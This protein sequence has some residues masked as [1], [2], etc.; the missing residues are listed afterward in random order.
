MNYAIYNSQGKILRTVHCDPSQAA[1]QAQEGEYVTEGSANDET[2]YVKDG[3]IID[4]P[5]NPSTIDKTT[6]IADDT[7]ACLISNI[8]IGSKVSVEGQVFTVNDSEFEF[9]VDQSGEYRI[10]ITGFPF[11]PVTFTVVAT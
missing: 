7:D 1:I 10:E 6:I 2:Q 4:R 8:P 9:T 3:K 11:L 5:A